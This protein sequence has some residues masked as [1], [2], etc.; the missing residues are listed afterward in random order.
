MTPA[1][2]LLEIVLS[3][4][5]RAL[6]ENLQYPGNAKHG[7]P[8][9]YGYV[10]QTEWTE[11]ERKIGKAIAAWHISAGAVRTSSIKKAESPKIDGV[12]RP[13]QGLVLLHS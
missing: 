5:Q 11:N 9:K 1:P 13:V 12:F 3:E 2:E 6:R 8:P 10:E 7:K 4:F